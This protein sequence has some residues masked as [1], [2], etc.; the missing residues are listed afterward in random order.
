MTSAAYPSQ[1]APIVNLSIPTAQGLPPQ[2][3]RWT[4]AIRLIMAIPLFIVTF[5]VGIGAFFAVIA[6][7]FVALFTGELPPGIA[8]FLSYFLRLATRTSCYGALLTDQYAPFDGDEHPE[9]PIRIELPAAGPLNQLAVLG[10]IV[11]IVPAAIILQ[12]LSGGMYLL[13]F[14]FWIAA[15]ILGRLPVPVYAFASTVV[16]YNMRVEAYMLLLTS[17]YPWGWKGDTADAA[18]LSAPNPNWAPPTGPV[19]AGDAAPVRFDTQTG[20]PI[21]PEQTT[22]LPGS[23]S[24]D[25]RLDYVLTGW[26]MAWIWIAI[27]I[28]AYYQFTTNTVSFNFQTHAH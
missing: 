21:Y 3:E 15:L 4:I 23:G 8:G 1:A 10:R 18:S 20:L 26:S 13:M 16:R 19:I 2:Q 28:G 25:G 9:Y 17:E 5:V 11:L 22:E 24:A 27:V 12:C 14:P 6:G 7:W